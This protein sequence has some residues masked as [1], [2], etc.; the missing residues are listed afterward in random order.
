MANGAPMWSVNP[1]AL[2]ELITG[3]D[4]FREK[5]PGDVQT[6]LERAFGTKL[7]AIFEAEGDTPGRLDL[8]QRL[9][10]FVSKPQTLAEIERLPMVQELIGRYGYPAEAIRRVLPYLVPVSDATFTAPGAPPSPA[11][12]G[13]VVGSWRAVAPADYVVSDVS[14][15]DPVQ[16][17]IADCYLIS[18]MISLAWSRPADWTAQVKETGQQYTYKFYKGPAANPKVKDLKAQLPLNENKKF[19]YARS[20]NPAET[21]PGMFEKAYVMSELGLS[22]EPTPSEYKQ[23]DR[24]VEPQIACR[25]LAG[26][27]DQV[28]RDQGDNLF[29]HIWT[30]CGPR[31]VTREP[32]MAWTWDQTMI[33]KRGFTWSGTA[34]RREHAYAV[35]GV[36]KQGNPQYVVLRDPWG[37]VKHCGETHAA[38]RQ[39]TPG[40]GT[41]G[42]DTVNLNP[43][44]GV[45]A[46]RKDVFDK[47]FQAIGW[48]E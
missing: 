14:Y 12:S 22:G 26:G 5:D 8:F 39:W 1:I 37:W 31:G 13:A 45:F 7:D 48:V 9:A 18:S 3:E 29:K 40:A 42:V 4:L 41:S 15:L 24:A 6:V 23:I 34:L 25:A 16:G 35:L 33:K 46:L 32:T 44:N 27:A 2:A 17:P 43:K 20:S 10:G 47:C 21:W 36:M 11:G 38:E 28:L 30:R 19:A